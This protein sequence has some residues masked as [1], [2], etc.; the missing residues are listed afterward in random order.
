MR[1][2]L[3]SASCAAADSPRDSKT[4]LQCV[5]V[6]AIAPADTGPVALSEVTSS[7]AA[8]TPVITVKSRAE[9]KPACN[10][11]D[12]ASSG[13]ASLRRLR[14]QDCGQRHFAVDGLFEDILDGGADFRSIAID[15]P[16]LLAFFERTSRHH[17]E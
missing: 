3:S 6:K 2:S 15:D 9:S 7:G 1:Q 16:D 14:R 8:L 12:V 17:L 10:G 5:V 11:T 13:R 4:T